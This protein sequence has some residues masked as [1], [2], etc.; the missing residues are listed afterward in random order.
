MLSIGQVSKITNVRVETIRYYERE[1]LIPKAS[2]STSGYRQFPD[3]I[4]RQINFIGQAKNLGFSLK[5]IRELLSLR[6]N[7]R[8]VCKDVRQ[9]TV[10]KVEE[11][12]LKIATLQKMIVALKP[13]IEECQEERPIDECPILNTLDKREVINGYETQD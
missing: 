8:S 2:R 9:K 1:G 11:I 13:L 5:D 3:S 7:K 6:N 12:E 10:T 4:I